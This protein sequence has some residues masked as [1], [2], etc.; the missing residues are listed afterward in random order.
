MYFV[1]HY[2][3]KGLITMYG[4]PNSHMSIRCNELNIPAIIGIGKKEFEN[5]NKYNQIEIN[6]LKNIIRII[7]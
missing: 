3:I 5:L 7:N 1:F 6:C 4:G 2:N